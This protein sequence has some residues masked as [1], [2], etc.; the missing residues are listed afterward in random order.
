MPIFMWL[1]RLLA[2]GKSV[3]PDVC[4]PQYKP[5]AEGMSMLKAGIL[6]DVC[7]GCEILKSNTKS[8]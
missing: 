5:D 4:G 2:K 3:S 1:R 8:S 6:S 7:Q